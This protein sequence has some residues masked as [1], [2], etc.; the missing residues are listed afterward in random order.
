MAEPHSLVRLEAYRRRPQPAVQDATCRDRQGSK[1]VRRPHIPKL[2][3]LHDDRPD[4]LTRRLVKLTNSSGG[5]QQADL[6][7]A[8]HFTPLTEPIAD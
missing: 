6:R 7:V 4:T 5:S 8:G 3:Q 2:S 1:S